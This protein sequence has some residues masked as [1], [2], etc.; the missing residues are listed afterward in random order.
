MVEPTMGMGWLTKALIGM[1]FIL[2]FM[3]VMPFMKKNF[4][5]N[6]VIVILSWQI[7]VCIGLALWNMKSGVFASQGGNI[8][9]PILFVIALAMTFGTAGN[10]LLSQ[11]VVEAP[12]PALPFAIFN[13]AAAVVYVLAI[14]LAI[15]LP[16]YFEAGSF[17]WSQMS[18]IV[19]VIGGLGLIMYKN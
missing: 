5:V 13:V 18:G 3:L 16:K 6:P 10:V 1:V 11:S 15:F 7:G 9:V 4:D 19:L 2:P 17:S 8:L 12:N 14:V